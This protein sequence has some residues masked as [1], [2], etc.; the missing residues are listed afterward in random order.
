[1]NPD[2]ARAL[3]AIGSALR[4]LLA[5]FCRLVEILARALHRALTR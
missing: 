1:M 5:T 2:M 3:S 4:A